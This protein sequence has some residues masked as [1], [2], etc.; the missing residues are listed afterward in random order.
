MESLIGQGFYL[1]VVG[2]AVVF[3][4]LI[5]MVVV[6]SLTSKFFVAHAHLFR[7]SVQEA[8]TPKPAIGNLDQEIAVAIAAAVAHSR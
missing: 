2:M 5:V 1:M 7:D 8:N 3:M 6:M 4:F